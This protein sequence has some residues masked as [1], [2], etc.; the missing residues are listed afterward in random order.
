[1]NT[2]SKMALA[3]VGLMTLAGCPGDDDNQNTQGNTAEQNDAADS[4]PL[5]ALDIP[6]ARNGV[7]FTVS[8]NAYCNTLAN[9]SG[10]EAACTKKAEQAMQ[11]KFMCASFAL[12]PGAT[13]TNNLAVLEAGLTG[14]Y[15]E[16]PLQY[17]FTDEELDAAIAQNNKALNKSDYFVITDIDNIEAADYG[18]P[19]KS[20]L[21]LDCA[22]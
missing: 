16:T 15:K 7:D 12:A 14:R 18:Y 4:K 22:P 19:D 8:V 5:L 6:V 1:M 20:L 13:K 9:N 11:Y 21:P 10:Y 2:R 17:L 3:F